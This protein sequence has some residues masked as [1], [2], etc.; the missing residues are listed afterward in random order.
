MKR[1]VDVAGELGY[2]DGLPDF[3]AEEDYGFIPR[4]NLVIIC[5]G[6]QGESRAA[7]AK[8]ARDEMKTRRA[9][10]G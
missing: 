7:L 1:V 10:A 6:S 3:I 9:V 4:E 8:L 2:M 5:T